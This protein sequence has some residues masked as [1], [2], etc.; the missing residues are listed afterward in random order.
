MFDDVEGQIEIREHVLD[1]K[2]FGGDTRQIQRQD[3]LALQHE[4]HLEQWVMRERAFGLQLFHQPLEGQIL[5]C[6]SPE[7]YLLYMIE[8]LAHR[9]VAGNLHANGERVDK[10]ADEI[11]NFGHW[12][13]G[14]RRAHHDVFFPGIPVQQH[15]ISRH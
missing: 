14:D 2:V 4:H 8:K 11:F 3:F 6:V 7:R 15:L 12:P 9:R 5:I 1:A 13:S 10:K